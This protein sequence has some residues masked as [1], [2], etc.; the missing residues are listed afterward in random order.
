MKVK[1]L[2]A[3]ASFDSNIKL[4]YNKVRVGAHISRSHF[5]ICFITFLSSPFAFASANPN[6]T[7]PQILYHAEC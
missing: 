1:E 4:V 2:A 7:L 3:G 5:S 6:V